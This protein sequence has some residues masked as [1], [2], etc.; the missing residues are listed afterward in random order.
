MRSIGELAGMVIDQLDSDMH[1]GGCHHTGGAT[2]EGAGPAQGGAN[3]PSV[4]G[5]EE[6]P[7]WKGK[8]AEAET[9]AKFYRANTVGRD[10]VL[11]FPP[12]IGRSIATAAPTRPAASAVVIDMLMWREGHATLANSP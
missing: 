10:Q 9:S 7:E 11:A 12:I 6:A 5:E 2:N 4:S 3:R 1:F 8:S